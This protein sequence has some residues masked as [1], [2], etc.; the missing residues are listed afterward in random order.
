MY[1]FSGIRHT[2]TRYCCFTASVRGSVTAGTAPHILDSSTYLRR[3]ADGAD[4]RV[5]SVRVCN[6][7]QSC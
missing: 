3:C 7:M 6:E 2:D 4:M 5:A 1:I